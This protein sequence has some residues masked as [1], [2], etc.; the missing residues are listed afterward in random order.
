MANR[1]QTNYLG[2][3]EA[4]LREIERA[5]RALSDNNADVTNIDMYGVLVAAR[6]ALRAL[7]HDYPHPVEP[8]KEARA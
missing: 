3:V 2:K 6:Q 8:W 1:R 5:A 7:G 4:N